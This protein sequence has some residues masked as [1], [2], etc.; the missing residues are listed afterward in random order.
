MALSQC[1]CAVTSPP[2]RRARIVLLLEVREGAERSV[3]ALRVGDGR[4]WSKDR[5]GDGG[6]GGRALACLCEGWSQ[7][8]WLFKKSSI[9]ID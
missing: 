9:P 5:G 4:L 2:S 1:S 8:I 6:E 3:E 7:V